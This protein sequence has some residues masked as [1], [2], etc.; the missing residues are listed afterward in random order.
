V[1]EN[2]VFDY[3]LSAASITDIEVDYQSAVELEKQDH[4]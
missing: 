3:L 2:Q 4:G 1:L